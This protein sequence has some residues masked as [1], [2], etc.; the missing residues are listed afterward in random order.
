MYNLFWWLTTTIRG[1][2]WIATTRPFWWW[3]ACAQQCNDEALMSFFSLISVSFPRKMCWPGKVKGV[4]L[5]YF[6]I[7]FGSN[8]FDFYLFCF[9]IIFLNWFCFSILSLNILFHLVLISNLVFI[10]LMLLLLF[11]I[12]FNFF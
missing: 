8:S 11:W 4:I 7:K 10:L 9:F 12:L 2:I 6:S 5:F 3:V 1:C